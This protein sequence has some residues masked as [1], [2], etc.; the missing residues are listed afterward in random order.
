MPRIRST[1]QHDETDCGAACLAC[2]AAYY[3]LHM[4]LAR[5]REYAS[6]GRSG[7]NVLGL[8]EAAEKMGLVAKGVKGPSEALKSAPLPA[9][10]HIIRSDRTQHFI[11]LAS[12]RKSRVTIMDPAEGRMVSVK[13]DDFLLQ[14]TGVLVILAPGSG[15][16]KGQRQPS[17]TKRFMQLIMPFRRTIIQ[18]LFGAFIYSLLGLSTAIYV[19]KIMDFVLVNL[20]TN[21]LN[22]M[23]LSMILLGILRNLIGYLKNL[24]L[25]KTGHQID[26]GLLTGYFRHL[27]SL[28]Q[29]FFDRM[30]TGEILS[31]MSDAIKIRNFIN[32]SLVDVI[33][34]ITSILLTLLAMA[35]L[36]RKL[37]LAVAAGIPIYAL[38]YYLYDRF[39]RHILRKTMERAA[40]LESELVESV[41]SSR[42]VKTFSL[43]HHFIERMEQRFIGFLSTGY[44]AGLSAIRSNQATEL[45]SGMITIAIMW[46]GSYM[47]CKQSLSPG[48][49][50][51]FYAMMGYLMRPVGGL[52][53]FGRSVREAGIA[54]DR[55]FQV[56]DLEQEKNLETGIRKHSFTGT[57]E[58]RNVE[59]GYGSRPLLFK[60][61]NFTIRAG[62][63]TGIA[64]R[65][66]S[67]KSSMASLLTALYHPRRG[68]I[69]M[70]GCEISQFNRKDL[71]CL[72]SLVPQHPELFSGTLLENIA[73]GDKD[74]DTGKIFQ[75]AAQTGLTELLN[76]L[77]DGLYTQIGERGLNLSGGEQQRLAIARSLYREPA[78]LILDEATSA[79]DPASEQAMLKMLFSHLPDR[80]TLIIISHKLRTVCQTDNILF[81]NNGRV[82]ESGSHSSLLQLKGH[83]HEFWK[84]QN[85]G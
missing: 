3:G 70:D 12:F 46:T 6:T 39:S 57:V 29:P 52:T 11:V 61:L 84:N 34:G 22:L 58:F 49:L 68:K 72:I 59:F 43:Q 17:R 40:E 35:F 69:L 42:L 23:S 20:N 1:R 15:F 53:G 81:L 60:D 85:A 50:M 25:L 79:L 54:A 26:G 30:K 44:R 38:I 31:R 76:N 62:S 83:Y 45:V 21:L 67:G 28:P 13:Q 73:P 51:S 47:V 66:G 74:P 19:Q 41:S 63:L 14:W 36:S 56:L 7:T 5:I 80:L 48:E 78:V 4:P 18:V 9:I 55:L 8:T 75:L 16:T 77:P 64:G 10:A 24:F 32:N 82:A 2:I 37:C 33:V 27:L 71:R 65:N